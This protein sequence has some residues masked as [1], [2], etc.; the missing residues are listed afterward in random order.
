MQDYFDEVIASYGQP[1]GEPLSPATIDKLRGKVPNGLIRCWEKYGLGTVLDG[2][3]QFVDPTRY[4]GVCEA[5]FD[6]DPELDPTRSHI[7]GL[8]AFGNLLIWNEK[9]HI[10]SIDLV[11]LKAFGSSLEKNEESNE[12]NLA[13]IGGLSVVDRPSFDERDSNGE[14][15][16]K[17]ALQKLGRLKPNQIYGFVPML[18]LGGNRSIDNLKIVSAPEHLLMLAQV[19][20]VSLVD[21]SKPYGHKPRN[22]G[23]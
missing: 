14:G 15:L 13:L 9:Y 20:P 18:A 8:S 16:F 23:G 5:V 17:P 2:F 7:I 6:G 12:K 21:M 22:I 10:I 11:N 1:A 4:S 19:G 3:F